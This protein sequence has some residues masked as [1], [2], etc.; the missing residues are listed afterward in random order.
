MR[1][2]YLLKIWLL[3]HVEKRA[4]E[5]TFDRTTTVVMG[6][7]DTG[8]SCLLKS[9]YYAFGA[10]PTK[11]SPEWK[12]ANPQILVKFAIDADEF[13]ILRSNRIFGIY[14]KK[15]K[16]I[17]TYSGITKGVGPKIAQLMDFNLELTDRGGKSSIPPPAYCFLPFYIDQDIGWLKNWSSFARLEQMPDFKRDLAYFHAG[18][19]P[20]EYY[21]L[22]GR[23]E[24]HKREKEEIDDERVVLQKTHTNLRD[25]RKN[26]SF[27]LSIEEYQ[28]QVDNLL[29][30]CQILYEQRETY[31]K[32]LSTLHTKK[33][34]LAEQMN[35]A[36]GAL[37]ELDADFSF[38]E[39]VSET[40]IICP[41]CGTSH[42]NSFVNRFSLIS[43]A[44]TCREF[45]LNAQGEMMKV[46]AEIL[47]E[48]KKL[49]KTQSNIEKIENILAE[50][51]GKLKLQDLIESEGEKQLDKFLKKEIGR[52]ETHIGELE[53]KIT[54]LKISMKK[55]EDK[56][57]K[58]EIIGFFQK[59][60]QKFLHELNVVNANLDNFQDVDCKINETGSDG[61]RAML[62]YYYSFL[63]TVAKYSTSCFCPLVIDT[64][65]QQDQDNTNAKAMISFA[66]KNAPKG[67]QLIL[68]T[69]KLHGV[70][71]EGHRVV[72]KE[73]SHLLQED[74]YEKVSKL[75]AP[76]YNQLIQ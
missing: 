3:S 62:A 28:S 23:V 53:A 76:F 13:Y 2:F 11:I 34:L 12:K 19:K 56:D 59:C 24:N 71:Y 50:K 61:P 75:T 30:E 7:N 65:I 10:E 73:K 25:K 27:P 60:M 54:D 16:I 21:A 4:R 1:K 33:A 35:V 17:E 6:E 70:P 48:A 69:V 49:D 45:L 36:K 58:D 63:H 15:G 44:E 38:I 29:K 31:Q 57:R 74:E 9:I 39:D 66:L 18:I 5:V 32:Q 43:D 42:D 47:S 64:P 41:T 14:D 26:I 40:N 8:K 22:K 67:S 72:N 46:N 37:E 20:K 52:L 68:G 51:H 55:Y